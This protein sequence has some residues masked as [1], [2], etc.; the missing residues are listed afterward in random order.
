MKRAVLFLLLIYGSMGSVWSENL[1]ITLTPNPVTQ[2]KKIRFTVVTEI[3]VQTVSVALPNTPA[4]LQLQEIDKNIYSVNYDIPFSFPKGIHTATVFLRTSNGQLIK[5]PVQF[6]VITAI[7]IPS[8][9]KELDGAAPKKVL[10]MSSGKIADLHIKIE[11]M[12]NELEVLTRDKDHLE[13]QIKNLEGEVQQLRSNTKDKRD[14]SKKEDLLKQLKKDLDDQEGVLHKAFS[15]LADRLKQLAEAEEEMKVRKKELTMLE[16]KLISKEAKIG[17]QTQKLEKEKEGLAKEQEILLTKKQALGL[18]E[19]ELAALQENITSQTSHIRILS[20]KLDEEQKLVQEK[21]A[22]IETEKKDLR[23]QK[24]TLDRQQKQTVEDKINLEKASLAF[25]DEQKEFENLKDAEK[26]RILKKQTELREKT[27]EFMK[28][29]EAQQSQK[30]KIE[31]TL[32]VLN[33]KDILL[34]EKEKEIMGYKKDIEVMERELTEKYLTLLD[35]KEWVAQKNEAIQQTYQKAKE[36]RWESEDVFQAQFEK[37][38]T[39]SQTIQKQSQ[40]LRLLNARLAERNKELEEEIKHYKASLHPF[41][42][43][44]Y[45]GHRVFHSDR[46]L[47]PSIESGIKFLALLKDNLSLESS[48]GFV[49]TKLSSSS[50]GTIV[51]SFTT[52]GIH[53]NY[54]LVSDEWTRFFLSVGAGGDVHSNPFGLN[55]GGGFKWIHSEDFLTRIELKTG[56]DFLASFGFEK[57]LDMGKTEKSLIPEPSAASVEE[58]KAEI[59][60]FLSTPTPNSEPRLIAHVPSSRSHLHLMEKPNFKDLSTHW[61]KLPIEVLTQY[62]IPMTATKKSPQDFFYPS[63]TVSAQEGARWL[64]VMNQ[65]PEFLR[66]QQQVTPIAFTIMDP[67]KNAYLVSVDV[68]DAKGNLHRTLLQKA[69]FYS[70]DHFL[71]WDGKDNQKKYVP[72]GE[73]T[74]KLTLEDKDIRIAEIKKT[75][76]VQPLELQISTKNI[77]TVELTKLFS[78]TNAVTPL[79]RIE[80]IRAVSKTLAFFEAKEKALPDLSKYADYKEL[81]A[82]SKSDQ[83]YLKLYVNTLGYGGDEL[84]RLRPKSSITRAEAANMMFRLLIWMKKTKIDFNSDVVETQKFDNPK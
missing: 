51:K 83:P 26:E 39:V 43:I 49:P 27:L 73:Y 37:M 61:A 63:Q 8:A 3:P 55:I 21:K 12:E 74:V 25:K 70:G 32:T 56:R 53:L 16:E 58:E 29:E 17:V 44:P 19:S 5:T 76:A 59:A 28:M 78:K 1:R 41:S 48:L 2:G 46:N 23:E 66:E 10:S 38:Q 11:E 79:T 82:F 14:I 36:V 57:K 6:N 45:L 30:A 72:F 80:Y 65:L 67:N 4:S 13:K 75:I 9:K 47:E 24:E 64:N 20:K 68:E 35:L 60:P 18:K 71:E 22:K 50:S 7:N 42:L 69:V 84:K 31:D 62:G 77:S 52:Y 15:T 81:D 34:K 54:D 33:E 40:K